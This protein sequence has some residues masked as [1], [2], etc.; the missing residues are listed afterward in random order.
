MHF[1]KQ[2]KNEIVKRQGR[3]AMSWTSIG[4]QREIEM[5]RYSTH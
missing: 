3:I 4:R 2:D 1:V 5:E